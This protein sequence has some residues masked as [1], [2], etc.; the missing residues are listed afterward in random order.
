MLYAA[1]SKNDRKERVSG[2]EKLQCNWITPLSRG[3]KKARG[4]GRWL[5]PRRRRALNDPNLHR[6]KRGSA[7]HIS[8]PQNKG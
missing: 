6:I 8:P 4:K 3:A 1:G 7:R 5:V 2:R